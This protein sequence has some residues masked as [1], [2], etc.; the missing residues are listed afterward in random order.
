METRLIATSF[1]STEGKDA[2][3]IQE[4]AYE[5][6]PIPCVPGKQESKT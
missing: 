3:N 6:E 2:H 5:Q 1:D 4:I